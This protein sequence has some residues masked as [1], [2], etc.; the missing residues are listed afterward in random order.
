MVKNL[1]AN[2]G[3]IGSIPSLG[4]GI[5]HAAGQLSPCVTTTEPPRRA[6]K[7]QLL[8]PACPG[9]CAPP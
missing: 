1:P 9:A 6:L 8:K 4:T 7:L 5:P 2:A 3:D